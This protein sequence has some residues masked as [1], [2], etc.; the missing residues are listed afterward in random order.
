M[1]STANE[2]YQHPHIDSNS[3]GQDKDLN[4]LSAIFAVRSDKESPKKV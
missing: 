4:N 3:N 2:Q 1:L